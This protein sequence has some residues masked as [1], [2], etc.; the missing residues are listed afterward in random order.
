[1]D[2]AR[3][4]ENRTVW[5]DQSDYSRIPD[6]TRTAL[7]RYSTDGHPLGG[8]LQALVTDLSFSEVVSRADFENRNALVALFLY[9]QNEMPGESVGSQENYNKW[10]WRNGLAGEKG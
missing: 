9:V 3:I 7:D 4:L 1:M 10:V 5:N 2:P 6:S 8:F